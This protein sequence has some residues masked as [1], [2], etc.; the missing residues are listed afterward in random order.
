MFTAVRTVMVFADDPEKCARWWA[1][2]LD[3]EVRLEVD[4]G[5]VYAWLDVSGI[6]LGFHPADETR[7][8]RGGSPVVYWAVDHVDAVRTR[9]LDAGC[10]HHRGPIEA[11]PGR[12]ICQLTDPFGTIFGIDG[13]ESTSA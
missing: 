13:P 5:R 3:T 2:V 8:P 11:E 4:D 9:L 12:K 10:T 1:S 6:E 7:N